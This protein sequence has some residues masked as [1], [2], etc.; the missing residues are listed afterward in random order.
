MNLESLFLFVCFFVL[1]LLSCRQWL[2]S[3]VLSSRAAS[4]CWGCP[5]E[6]PARRG[7]DKRDRA[8]CLLAVCC[9]V[10]NLLFALLCDFIVIFCSV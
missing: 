8:V 2:R 10:M 3:G 7:K 5:C 4:S 9:L 6:H 1:M